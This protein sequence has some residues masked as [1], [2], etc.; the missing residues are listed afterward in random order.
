MKEFYLSNDKHN[1]RLLIKEL[2]SILGVDEIELS[3]LEDK[4]D[5]I[6]LKSNSIEAIMNNYFDLFEQDMGGIIADRITAGMQ[7]GIRNKY[8]TFIGYGG[9]GTVNDGF[10][11]DENTYFSLDSISKV[12]T[13]I[14]TFL[15]IRDGK[16]RM[17]SSIN[18]INND[19]GADCTVE[20]I[21]KFRA[22]LQTNK[23]IDNLSREETISILKE[24]REN[25]EKK[26]NF[27]NYYQYNDIGYMILRLSLPQFLERL[28]IVLKLIDDSNLTYNNIQM[29]EITTGGR[30]GLEYVTPDT[31]G[32]GIIFPGHTGMYANMNGLLNLGYKVFITDSVLTEE[33]KNLL[34]KQ[35]Y[36][37]PYVYNED[38]TIK[39]SNSGKPIYTTKISGVYHKPKNITLDDFNKMFYL[40]FSNLTTD[41][42]IASTGTC[43]SWVMS[44]DLSQNG[45]FGGY[46]GGILTNP[47]SFVDI[48]NYPDD[49]NIIPNANLIVNKKGIILGYPGKLNHYKDEIAKYGILLELLT[50]YIK[51]NDKELLDDKEYTLV[52]K[53]KKF[54]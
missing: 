16:I 8:F 3:F 10:A 52:R 11:I 47:Y 50:E 9:S 23:R 44:D 42:A 14:I 31:K 45:R 41:E 21:L 35:P 33:E 7:V 34:L 13:S 15:M 20:D 22:M 37:S 26:K 38:G 19:F 48:G 49:K 17:D 46:V 51:V 18:E 4:L 32:R 54:E 5:E 6:L 24:C 30:N 28:D 27:K 1:I 40:D 12:F 36:E 39:F 25:L 53:L 43:G 29:K 2:S